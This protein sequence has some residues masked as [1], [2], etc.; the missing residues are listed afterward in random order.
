MKSGIYKIKNVVNNKV[1][2]GQAKNLNT[3]YREHL[4]YIK[5]NKHYNYYL[6]KSFE[7]YGKEN[8]NYSILEEVEDDSLLNIREKYWIDYYGGINS[9]NTYNFKDPLLNEYNDY[10][11]KKLSKSS[12][13][14]NNPNYGNYWTEEQK[15]N[16]S[17]NKKGKSWE[18]LYGIEKSKKM[19]K[20]LSNSHEGKIVKEETKEKLRKIN[21]GSGNPAYGKG[22][23]QRGEKNPM[24]GKPSVTRR[25]VLR[26]DKNGNFIKRYE[27]LQEVAEDGFNVGNVSSAANGK[28]KSSGGFIW[29]Y[30]GD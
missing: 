29:K 17:K 3:R 12:S 28:L 23:R 15:E 5:N 27:F 19:K 21:I 7:K 13:G 4:Y 2:I 14:K 30:E 16:S 11:R 6:Q 1:Y 25:L 22:D 9:N 24:Y 8:F 26:F 10:I 18:E 20:K